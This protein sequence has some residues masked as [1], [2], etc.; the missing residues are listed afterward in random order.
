MRDGEGDTG[1]VPL[2]VLVADDE[3]PIRLMCKVNLELEGMR[4]IEAANGQEA[5]DLALEAP[6]DVVLLDITMPRLDGWEVAEELRKNP[7]TAHVPVI[8][9]TATRTVETE[10]RAKGGGYAYLAKP[11]NPLDLPRLV[12]HAAGV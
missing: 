6:P 1:R 7:A 4:V 3:Q 11:F 8:F 2:R 5:L 9:V 10:R 12:R